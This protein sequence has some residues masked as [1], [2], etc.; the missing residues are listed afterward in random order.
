MGMMKA[1]Q[2]LVSLSQAV[3]PPALVSFAVLERL[4]SHRDEDA[5]D[6]KHQ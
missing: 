4:V 6:A 5:Y 3:V 2:S 1:K